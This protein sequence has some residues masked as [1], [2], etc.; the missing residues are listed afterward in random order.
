[1]HDGDLKGYRI[2]RSCPKSAREEGVNMMQRQHLAILAAILFLA[3]AC[4]AGAAEEKPPADQERLAQIA[5]NHPDSEKRRQAVLDLTD[6]SSLKRVVLHDSNSNVRCEAACRLFGVDPQL[7][8]NHRKNVLTIALILLE[9]EIDEYY[10]GLALEYRLHQWPYT[11]SRQPG[12]RPEDVNVDGVV[13]EQVWVKI[14]LPTGQILCDRTFLGEAPPM[15]ISPGEDITRYRVAE[16]EIPKIVTDVLQ[17]MDR[18]S[19]AVLSKCRNELVSSR[20][21]AVLDSGK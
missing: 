10:G 1:M 5:L 15:T 14:S 4:S 16:V 19:L 18:E 17:P 9:P 3:L 6:K 7:P 2:G 8:D 13:Q 11:Y 20:A 12:W 21:R